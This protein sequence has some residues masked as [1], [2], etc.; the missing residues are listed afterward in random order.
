M[1]R[2]YV[3]LD[4]GTSE[5]KAALFDER[6]VQLD[7]TRERI[8]VLRP[9]PGHSELDP[10]A[11]LDAT[12]RSLAR[13]AERASLRPGCEITAL[14]IT[15]AMVGAW[16]LDAS[17]AATGPGILWDDCRSE[18]V[19][20][21]LR[22]AHPDFDDRVFSSSGSVLQQGCT[23]PLMAWMAREAPRR[24]ADA[25]H[26]V[27]LKD[28]LRAAL[29]GVIATDIG[30]AA[31][32]PGDA[33]ARGRSNAMLALFGLERWADRLPVARPFESL[34]GRIRPAA[35]AR[36]GLPEG[37]PVAIGAG[38]VPSSVLGAGGLDPGTTTVVLGTTCLVGRCSTAP[39]FEPHGLGLLFT[40]PGGR[41]FRAMV[42][43]AGTA[44]LDWARAVLVPALGDD[45]D[46]IEALAASAPPGAGGATWLPYLSESGII[47]P[48]VDASARAGFDG[49][50]P[51]T[52]SADLVRAVYEGTAHAVVDC[53]ELLGGA[54]D[55]PVRLVGGGARSALWTQMLADVLR[56]P[57]ERVD[58]TQLGA[59][60]AAML[61]AVAAGHHGS[62]DEVAAHA[63]DAVCVT[64]P[65][66]D[67]YREVRAR[68]L[69][70][71]DRRLVRP[72]RH[73]V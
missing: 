12:C 30:E 65:G 51:R 71:R 2:L 27:G 55:R 23:L 40:V 13:V 20:E 21:E 9:E 8:E 35:A 10:A 5:I 63:I 16:T 61:A 60:G 39:S 32:A 73:V 54:A 69:A 67:D 6:F 7:E 53:V 58:A 68:W 62:V 4:A 59:R 14:G 43:V 1:G 33:R 25:A 36:C 3:G 26:V 42:N 47:A 41:W 64:E 34:A 45:F 22:T 56:R 38:D 66:T 46:A 70:H 72:D 49:I 19:L 11:V 15:G 37:L 18:P 48:V 29:T 57:V 50:G 31:V 24:L 17:G 28:Y 52:T 44:N